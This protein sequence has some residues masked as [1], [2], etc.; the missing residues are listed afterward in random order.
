[1]KNDRSGCDT[2]PRSVASRVLFARGF[3][4]VI[5][6]VINLVALYTMV[7]VATSVVRIGDMK[8][9]PLFGIEAEGAQIMRPFCSFKLLAKS[10]NTDPFSRP[11]CEIPISQLI[12]I[13]LIL[14]R[15]QK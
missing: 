11:E 14:W 8:C 9:S 15:F 10:M 5:S 1:M 7:C 4:S 2:E 6:E 13:T 3:R 12:P